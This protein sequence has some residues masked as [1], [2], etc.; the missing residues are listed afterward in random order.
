M[1]Q[2]SEAGKK[3]RQLHSHVGVPGGSAWEHRGHAGGRSKARRGVQ[4]QMKRGWLSLLC[5]QR[6]TEWVSAGKAV[7]HEHGAAARKRCTEREGGE[8]VRRA[9]VLRVCDKGRARTRYLS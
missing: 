3:I 2:V 6:R 8:T 9:T 5:R 4:L 1:H 7:G